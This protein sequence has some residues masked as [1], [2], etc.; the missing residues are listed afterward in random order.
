VLEEL[1]CDEASGGE[2]SESES[3]LELSH[4]SEQ[5]SDATE[6]KATLSSENPDDSRSRR[7]CSFWRLAEF[8]RPF[9]KRFA[10][11]Y[12]TVVCLFVYPVCL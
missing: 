6:R 5:M 4:H 12:R 3:S 9:V 1:F 2:D 8:R 11:R 10:L 7:S